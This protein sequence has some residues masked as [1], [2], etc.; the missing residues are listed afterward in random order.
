VIFKQ[1]STILMQVIRTVHDSQDTLFHKI[2]A[3][4]Q[5]ATMKELGVPEKARQLVYRVRSEIDQSMS[6]LELLTELSDKECVQQVVDPYG[7]AISCLQRIPQFRSPMQKYAC[8]MMA[9]RHIQQV[10]VKVYKLDGYDSDTMT[11][12][13]MYCILKANIPFLFSEIFL[14]D[15]LF[16]SKRLEL[17]EI[18]VR[19]SHFNMFFEY[20]RS[21]D[22]KTLIQ[23]MMEEC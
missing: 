18:R 20:F 21:M 19:L 15:E 22:W 6:H 4:Y 3:E 5:S 9:S 12:I 7:D 14:M 17:C 16:D 13:F 2:T 11:T 10:L 8:V 23:P 1:I